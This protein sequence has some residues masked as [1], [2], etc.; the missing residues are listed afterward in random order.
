LFASGLI[1]GEALIGIG[2]AVPIVVSGTPDV[3]T[4]GIELPII[5]GVL[6]IAALSVALYRVATRSG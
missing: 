5:V 4:L 1:T 2:M 3:I 6:V